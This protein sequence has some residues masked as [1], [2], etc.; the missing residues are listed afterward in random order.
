MAEVLAL[1]MLVTGGAYGL[2]VLPWSRS[3]QSLLWQ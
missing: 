3:L 1:V 2:P